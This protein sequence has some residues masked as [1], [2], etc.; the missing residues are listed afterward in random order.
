MW[1]LV[2]RLRVRRLSTRLRPVL[3]TIYQISAKTSTSTKDKKEENPKKKAKNDPDSPLVESEGDTAE[4]A[5]PTR[6]TRSKNKEVATAASTKDDEAAPAVAASATST[7]KNEDES[8]KQDETNKEENPFTG[9]EATAGASGS[10]TE[11]VQGAEEKKSESQSIE[12]AAAEAGLAVIQTSDSSPTGLPTDNDVAAAAAAGAEGIVAS[13][14]TPA[15]GTTATPPEE[16][17]YPYHINAG[18]DVISGKGGKVQQYN[19]HFRNLVAE[20]YPAYDATTSKIAKRRIGVAI[21]TT[22]VERG[23]RFLDAEGK[24]MDRPKGVLK[25]MKALKVRMTHCCHYP[26]CWSLHWLTLTAFL[27]TGRQDMDERW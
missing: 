26:E 3:L 8:K 1:L 10:A 18:K 7:E 9:T 23:G 11:A 13:G 22:I 25:V 21:Y 14:E 5:K 4:P 27:S 17:P 6:A 15:A 24:E 19:R 12:D 16:S 2:L 20:S